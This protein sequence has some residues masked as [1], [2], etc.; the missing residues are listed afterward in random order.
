MVGCVEKGAKT[1]DRDAAAD[2]T[3]CRNSGVY[4]TQKIP[5]KQ[6]TTKLLTGEKDEPRQYNIQKDHPV[7][8]SGLDRV[9]SIAQKWMEAE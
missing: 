8:N 6:S 7:H 4:S 3:I 2:L 1:R 5:N 9:R